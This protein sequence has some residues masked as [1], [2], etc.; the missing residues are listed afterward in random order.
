MHIHVIGRSA[1]DPAWP[2]TVW[3]FEGKQ[4]YG[5]EEIWKIRAAATAALDL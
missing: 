2:G 1:D 3:A 5:D 4:S